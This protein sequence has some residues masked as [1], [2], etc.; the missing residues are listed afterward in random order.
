MNCRSEVHEK[1]RKQQTSFQSKSINRKAANRFSFWLH[2][3]C[4]LLKNW[5]I[6][7]S[8]CLLKWDFCLRRVKTDSVQLTTRPQLVK[9][10]KNRPFECRDCVAT[11]WPQMKLS[12]VKLTVKIVKCHLSLQKHVYF[13]VAAAAG[14]YHFVILCGVWVV[15]VMKFWIVEKVELFVCVDI[16]TFPIFLQF[17]WHGRMYWKDKFN[18]MNNYFEKCLQKQ[19]HAMNWENIAPNMV[20]IMLNIEIIQSPAGHVTAP[21]LVLSWQVLGLLR[22]SNLLSVNCCE[23]ISYR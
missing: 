16:L 14:C 23:V 18:H 6:I 19:E 20:L 11:S 22:A 9:F 3:L 15:E 21:N 13:L 12:R 1:Q 4:P 17:F 10:S 2:F 7:V 5:F 8:L